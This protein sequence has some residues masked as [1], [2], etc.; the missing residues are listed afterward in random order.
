LAISKFL[1]S[2]E[3]SQ[4]PLAVTRLNLRRRM[5]EP[6]TYDAEVGVSAYDRT[7]TPVSSAKPTASGASSGKT[8]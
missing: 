8:P 7:E 1:E 6:D 5:G 4:L 2:L 3:Q